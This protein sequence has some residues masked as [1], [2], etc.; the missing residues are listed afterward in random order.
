MNLRFLNKLPAV[1]VVVAGVVV[2]ATPLQFLAESRGTPR[3]LA[4]PTPAACF[5]VRSRANAQRG[6]EAWLR[7]RP[8]GSI[9][10][11][12]AAPSTPVRCLV[13]SPD[14]RWAECHIGPVTPDGMSYVVD[15]DTAESN[16]L[17]CV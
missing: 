6:A 11:S 16:N 8:A 2:V 13:V 9:W 4:P 17:G 1:L 15:C 12:R 10:T 14:G 5:G 7:S 3:P